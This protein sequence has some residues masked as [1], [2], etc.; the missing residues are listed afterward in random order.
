M[1]QEMKKVEQ[2]STGTCMM[3]AISCAPCN[4]ERV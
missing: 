1:G 2:S 3:R 4:L